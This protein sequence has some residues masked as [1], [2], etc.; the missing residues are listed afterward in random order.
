MDYFEELNQ[1]ANYTC[2]HFKTDLISL[3]HKRISGEI[4]SQKFDE[5]LIGIEFLARM[6]MKKEEI[7]RVKLA[8]AK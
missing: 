2:K 4:S 7:A 5:H 1:L 6:E 3:I 8:D